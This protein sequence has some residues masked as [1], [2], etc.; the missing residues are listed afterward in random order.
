MANPRIHTQSFTIDQLASALAGDEHIDAGRIPTWVPSAQDWIALVAQPVRLGRMRAL[1]DSTS[2]FD[3]TYV[4]FDWSTAGSPPEANAKILPFAPDPSPEECH[5]NAADHWESVG[6]ASIAAVMKAFPAST[7]HVA[8]AST[9]VHN[10]DFRTVLRFALRS[11]SQTFAAIEGGQAPESTITFAAP[12]CRQCGTTAVDY[13]YIEGW[14]RIQSGC[15]ACG[16]RQEADIRELDYRVDRRVLDAAVSLAQRPAARFLTSSEYNGGALVSRTAR[17]ADQSGVEDGL[18][19][20]MYS[21]A[22]FALI[23]PPDVDL[24][25]EELVL[26]ATQLDGRA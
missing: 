14:D 7:V 8:R 6:T 24:D 4:L 26:V 25:I 23:D 15:A 12:V 17:L 5:A 11:P 2:E 10:A 20:V 21:V 18:E 16:H 3:I 19:S 13:E 22:P 9:F 1:H